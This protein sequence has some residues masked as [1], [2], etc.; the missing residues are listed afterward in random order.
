[1]KCRVFI[2]CTTRTTSVHL[3]KGNKPTGN[4]EAPNQTELYLVRNLILA[5]TLLGPTWEVPLFLPKR[6]P[7][8]RIGLA[9][10]G[11]GIVLFIEQSYP[12][13]SFYKNQAPNLWISR[14][15]KGRVKELGLH[16]KQSK[17]RIR[18][19][20][21]ESKGIYDLKGISRTLGNVLRQ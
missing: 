4:S 2:S 14:I 7:G 13:F 12:S 21:L 6:R 5:M 16:L 10:K 8:M 3:T 19:S 11:K 1:M 17:S 9:R 15:R 18:I 20:G